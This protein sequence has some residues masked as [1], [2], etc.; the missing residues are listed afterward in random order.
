MESGSR[1]FSNLQVFRKNIFDPSKVKGL[2]LPWDINLTPI[3]ISTANMDVSKESIGT[4]N[5][6]NTEIGS[7]DDVEMN[8]RIP[9][10]NMEASHET[11]STTVVDPTEVTSESTKQECLDLKLYEEG[12]LATSKGFMEM[13]EEM[14][15]ELDS[16][17]E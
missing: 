12:G 13:T 17:V 5:D 8:I 2:S 3:S 9:E 6:D 10:T 11:V 4:G 1:F 14:E 16:R 15:K 7:E